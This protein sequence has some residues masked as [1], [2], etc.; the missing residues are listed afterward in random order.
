M[1]VKINSKFK[2]IQ[3][4]IIVI[5]VLYYIISEILGKNIIFDTIYYLSNTDKRIVENQNYSLKLPYMWSRKNKFLI[6]HTF[7]DYS[8]LMSN[9]C[10]ED[11]LKKY[12]NI[13]YEMSTNSN[14]ELIDNSLNNILTKE[15]ICENVKPKYEQDKYKL[16]YMPSIKSCFLVN[17]SNANEPIYNEVLSSIQPILK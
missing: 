16:I 7:L 11:E 8:I 10:T 4:S 9:S 15:Y 14:I 12:K 6:E 17:Y 2:I 3:W 5:I 1:S 13:L